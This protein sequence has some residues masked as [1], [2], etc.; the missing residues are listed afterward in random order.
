MCVSA[1]NVYLFDQ[2]CQHLHFFPSFILFAMN[3]F[4]LQRVSTSEHVSNIIL[5]QIV[6]LFLIL[7]ICVFSF[8]VNMHM[9]C[10]KL[11]TQHQMH[12]AHVQMA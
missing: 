8:I 1:V 2:F 6:F 10:C 11:R 7:Y 9:L 12:T 5:W 4:T 3:I